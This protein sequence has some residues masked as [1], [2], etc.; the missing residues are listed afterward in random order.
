MGFFEKALSCLPPPI[1]LSI[2]RNERE[3]ERDRGGALVLVT[4]EEL[5][6]GR[7]VRG[8]ERGSRWIV[9]SCFQ[10]LN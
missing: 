1:D 3:G 6:G 7:Q 4:V 9:F 2:E 10:L 5:G 8:V